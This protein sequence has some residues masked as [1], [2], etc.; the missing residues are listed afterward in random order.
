MEK[1]DSPPEQKDKPAATPKKP[2]VPAAAKGWP[3]PKNT[4]APKGRAMDR[5]PGSRGSARGR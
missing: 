4:Y 1:K 2:D 3:T 5:K